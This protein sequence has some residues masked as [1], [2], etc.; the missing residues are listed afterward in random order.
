[1]SAIA[2]AGI[3][4]KVDRVGSTVGYVTICRVAIPK[5]E[6]TPAKVFYDWLGPKSTVKYG[7]PCKRCFGDGK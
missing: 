4:H 6:A 1:M 3:V 5:A 7:A 2:S